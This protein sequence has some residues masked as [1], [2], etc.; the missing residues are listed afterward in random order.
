MLKFA[1]LFG[2]MDFLPYV[3]HVIK[4]K[5]HENTYQKSSILRVKSI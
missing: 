4:T 2:S 3:C 1:L 5:H